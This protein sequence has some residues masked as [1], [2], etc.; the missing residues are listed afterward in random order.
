LGREVLRL[1]GLLVFA[2]TLVVKP[3][4]TLSDKYARRSV[5]PTSG[6]SASPQ[7]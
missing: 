3:D 7:A 1:K 2:H 5:L 6:I 4:G